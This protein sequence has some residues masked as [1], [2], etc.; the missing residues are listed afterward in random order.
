MIRAFHKPATVFSIGWANT[1]WKTAS[2]SLDIWNSDALVGTKVGVAV[3][4]R[5]GVA[6]IG[7]SVTIDAATSPNKASEDSVAADPGCMQYV[8]TKK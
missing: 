3:G 1:N 2:P 4:A 5:D 6:S 8:D 7:T